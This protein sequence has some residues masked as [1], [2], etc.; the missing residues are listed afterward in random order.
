MSQ[1]EGD[2]PHGISCPGCR[3]ARVCNHCG[4]PTTMM[5]GRC[6]SGRCRECC[7]KVCRHAV[8]GYSYTLRPPG[9]RYDR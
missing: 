9:W 1:H 5:T 7:P 8:D 2:R 4:K 6:V 3:A